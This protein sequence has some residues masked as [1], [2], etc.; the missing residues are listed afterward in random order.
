M[1]EAAGKDLD[2]YFRQ[3]LTQPGYPILDVRWKHGGKKLTLDI[4]QTAEAGVGDVPDPESRAL[5][6][7]EAGEGGREW[8]EDAHGDRRDRQEAEPGRG[9]S[10]WLVAAQDKQR[11][12]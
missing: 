8:A 9:G 2:W 12:R 4:A 11:K 7:W 10:E 1:S 5:G 3:S 6:G